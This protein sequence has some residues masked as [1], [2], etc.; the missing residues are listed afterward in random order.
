VAEKNDIT[1][2][3]AADIEKYWTGKLSYSEMHAMEKAAMDDPFLADAL[4]GYKNTTTVNADLNTLKERL[5]KKF[6][7]LVP[8]VPMKKRYPWLRVAAAI[9]II[10]AGGLFFQQIIFNN[11]PH[12]AIAI[13]NK[14][15]KKQA[16]ADTNNNAGTV[17]AQ[18]TPVP[19][20]KQG[21][22]SDIQPDSTSLKQNRGN[23]VTGNATTSKAALKTDTV[24]ISAGLIAKEGRRSEEE[25]K[26]SLVAGSVAAAD[27]VGIPDREKKPLDK[28]AT[29]TSRFRDANAYKF[30]AAAAP[31]QKSAE[32]DLYYYDG[33]NAGIILNHK[34]SYR[35]VD[36]QNNPVPFANVMNTDDRVGT[37]T[38][39]R[40]DFNLVSSDSVLN[41]QIRSLGYLS[42][43]YKLVPSTQ[44][45]SLTLKEDFYARRLMT[46]TSRHL[47]S[48]TTIKKD[49]AELEEPEVGWGN[50]NTYV[51][52]NIQIPETIRKKNTL[53][54]VE[55]SFDV[56]RNGNPTNIRVTKSSQCKECDE[57]AKRVLKEGPK[58]KKRGRRSKT[59]IS[60]AVDQK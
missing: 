3:T 43:N 55:L 8:V 49:T 12:N 22:Y 1:N 37:Y 7:A 39:I 5:D 18:T 19:S 32:R 44:F 36:A 17:Q 23:F 31:K 52:N 45:K 21:S 25:K 57:E 15:E 13:V 30:E 50:F 4:E 27:A 40:G 53:S 46:D 35:V 9:I 59:T 34:Y 41:V 28:N 48:S 51:A 33:K 26:D 6:I 2:F 56:D 42:G 20:G 60:I 11:K 47:V 10:I 24:N 58:W 16:D 38:D 29:D 14:E 54:N